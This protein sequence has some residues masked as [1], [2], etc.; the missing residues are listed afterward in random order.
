MP[1]WPPAWA[2]CEPFLVSQSLA[3]RRLVRRHEPT[4]QTVCTRLLV[5]GAAFGWLIY[6]M[7]RVRVLRPLRSV[8]IKVLNLGIDVGQVSIHLGD[9]QR[10]GSKRPP[11]AIDI[12]RRRS[13]VVGARLDRS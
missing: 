5:L 12:R 1:R 6:A 11:G 4:M 9:V 10:L 3:N 2:L 7:D 13:R 8:G